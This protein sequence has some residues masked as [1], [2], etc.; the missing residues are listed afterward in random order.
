VQVEIHRHSPQTPWTYRDL[1]ARQREIAKEVR[2]GE[3]DGCILLSEVAPVITYG[4]RTPKSDLLLPEDRY[5][6]LGVE[7]LS[8]DRGGLAT[9]H[10]P[11]QWLVFPVTTLA[12]LG[13]SKT[14]LR[15][16]VCRILK[17]GRDVLIR[18]LPDP[19]AVEIRL[20]PD[21]GLWTR[22]TRAESS[23]QPGKIASL[24]L[25]IDR[26]VVLHGLSVNVHPSATSF[27]GLN[28]CGL[29]ARVAYADADF[30]A[31]GQALAQEFAGI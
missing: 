17:I 4:K 31:V 23:G 24:G 28:P 27:V 26:G 29:N 19:D 11:G 8:V 7:L 25:R 30:M 5:A 6:E 16:G 14:A 15:S 21:T 22:G 20:S 18:F 10:G 1:D 13:G 9:W 12:R 3:S 2:E